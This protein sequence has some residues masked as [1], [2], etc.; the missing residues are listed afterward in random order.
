VL[1]VSFFWPRM[2]SFYSQVFQIIHGNPE[3]ENVRTK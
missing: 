3:T 2:K 1:L